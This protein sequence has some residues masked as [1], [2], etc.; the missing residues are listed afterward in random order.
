MRTHSKPDRRMIA[1]LLGELSDDERTRL[2]DDYVGDQDLFDELA[3]AE[4]ELIDA[5]VRG[6]L[7]SRERDRFEARYLSSPRGRD[8]VAFARSLARAGDR[9]AAP[10]RPPQARRPW[11]PA[12]L[13]WPS[14]ALTA[15]AATAVLAVVASVAWWSSRPSPATETPAPSAAA[16]A[17]SPAGAAA[18]PESR[19][20]GATAGDRAIALVLLPGSV[21]SPEGAAVLSV[22]AGADAVRIQVKHQGDPHPAYRVVISTPEGREVWSRGDLPPSQPGAPSLVVSLPAGA[23][24]PGDFVLTLSARQAGSG[25]AN[26]AEYSF[27]VARQ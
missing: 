24:R 20:P 1:Y 4:T 16:P 7:T 23:L 3:D 5:Y 25:F 6:A 12:W 11:R 8:R 19:P 21:R 17:E 9:I 2:E 18:P 22:P 13:S 27:R 26:I 14:P 10:D 15:A